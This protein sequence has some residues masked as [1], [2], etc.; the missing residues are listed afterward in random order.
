MDKGIVFS[1]MIAA[2]VSITAAIFWDKIIKTPKI[3]DET[4]LEK[5]IDKLISPNK[6]TVKY[7]LVDG[8]IINTPFN[9][10][11]PKKSDK[12]GRQPKPTA[13]NPVR[14]VNN[15][16]NTETIGN[17]ELSNANQTEVKTHI[18]RGGESLAR[19]SMIYY[20]TEKYWPFLQKYN[21]LRDDKLDIG[22][23]LL[24]PVKPEN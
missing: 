9:N 17:T 13:T 21:H 10:K 23:K 24:I 8:N 12:P 6:Q 3:E 20:K 1:I 11:K 18:V 19:I 15:T 7:D 2:I 5:K 16:D 4:V 14:N 22:Q